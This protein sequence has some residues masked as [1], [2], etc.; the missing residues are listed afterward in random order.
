MF[1]PL[2]LPAATTQSIPLYRVQAA[3]QRRNQG[4]GHPQRL[5][6]VRQMIDQLGVC[7][8][9]VAMPRDITYDGY[10]R[11]FGHAQQQRRA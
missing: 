6:A 3:L 1:E 7:P 8:R 9:T 5:A 4:T 2:E 10:G 11:I